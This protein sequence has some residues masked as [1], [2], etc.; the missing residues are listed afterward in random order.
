MV[1]QGKKTAKMRLPWSHD[2]CSHNHFSKHF[3]HLQI[4][5]MVKT[6]KKFKAV[7]TNEKGEITTWNSNSSDGKLLKHLV[8][9]GQAAGKT[10][11]QLVKEYP[12]F[13]K[14]SNKTL[15]SALTNTKR[16]FEAEVRAA[17]GGG[18]SGKFSHVR[19]L[20]LLAIGIYWQHAF[21]GHHNNVLYLSLTVSIIFSSHPYFL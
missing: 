3:V 4:S 5:K 18:S 8:A 20:V 6:P 2:S 16:C 7:K 11:S 1:S 15:N 19:L 13:Q 10:P 21:L 14:Y 9:D 17:R 12:Q